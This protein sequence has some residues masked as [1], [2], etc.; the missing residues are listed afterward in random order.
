MAGDTLLSKGQACRTE[1][2]LALRSV[3]FMTILAVT[4]K[5]TVSIGD[6][7]RGIA[8]ATE[9]NLRMDGAKK[10]SRV[11]NMI[12]HISGRCGTSIPSNLG[13]TLMSQDLETD[14]IERS[15]SNN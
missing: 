11:Q 15:M 10:K 5:T 3:N 7:I 2:S 12:R 14:T 13:S 6:S 4:L 1:P 9:S 8:D